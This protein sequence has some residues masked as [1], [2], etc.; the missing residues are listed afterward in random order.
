MRT[1]NLSGCN[2]R[3]AS[4]MDS[5]PTPPMVYRPSEPRSGFRR[6]LR[7]ASSSSECEKQYHQH[8]HQQ[9]Q[10][11][12]QPSKEPAFLPVLPPPPPPLTTSQ[13][14]SS[15]SFHRRFPRLDSYGR[16]KSSTCADCDD[17]SRTQPEPETAAAE[18]FVT[19]RAIGSGGA[20][21]Y[22]ALNATS[23]EVWRSRESRFA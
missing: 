17:S 4:S 14:N 8:L 18:R 12:Q 23:K 7:S 19:N 1:F 20:L 13:V 21:E 15:A 22:G 2:P 5:Q 11:Q 10:Q 16:L 6:Y 3:V 9:Q